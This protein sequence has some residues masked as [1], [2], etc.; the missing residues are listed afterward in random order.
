MGDGIWYSTDASCPECRG[1]WWWWDTLIS[2]WSQWT[3]TPSNPEHSHATQVNIACLTLPRL[4]LLHKLMIT[5]T[6]SDT[7]YLFIFEG[8]YLLTT[9]LFGLRYYINI[10]MCDK[11]VLQ[12][13]LACSVYVKWEKSWIKRCINIVML[14]HFGQ[15]CPLP[16]QSHPSSYILIDCQYFESSNSVM[17]HLL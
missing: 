8:I 4:F 13:F 1:Q 16:Y 5:W 11:S 7:N 6:Q 3:F 2:G 9:K 10:L 17:R 12:Q 14:C 15:F